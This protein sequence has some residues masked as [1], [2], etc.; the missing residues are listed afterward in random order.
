MKES[1]EVTSNLDFSIVSLRNI[2][3]TGSS[4]TVAF[5]PALSFTLM[6]CSGFT[7]DS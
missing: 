1:V 2:F 3:G 7:K 5:L 6:S 4:L